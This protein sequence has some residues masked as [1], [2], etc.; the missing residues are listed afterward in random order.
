MKLSDIQGQDD[1]E[2]EVERRAWSR[3]EEMVGIPY[4]A[5]PEEHRVIFE[6]GVATGFL[7]ALQMLRENEEE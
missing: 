4:G 6:S 5:V 1:L 7:I 2:I 3:L